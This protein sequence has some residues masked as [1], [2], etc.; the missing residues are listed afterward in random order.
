MIISNK[1]LKV[2]SINTS[3][4]IVSRD[5]SRVQEVQDLFSGEEGAVAGGGL[6]VEPSFDS[7]ADRISCAAESSVVFRSCQPGYVSNVTP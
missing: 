3:R 6:S 1:G 4:G 5:L 7:T 2:I